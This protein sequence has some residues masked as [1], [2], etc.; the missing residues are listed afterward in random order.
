M[1]PV[2]VHVYTVYLKSHCK[3]FP[4]NAVMA[5]VI[6]SLPRM[7]GEANLAQA[8]TKVQLGCV[9]YS[10]D[11]AIGNELYIA[12]LTF[13]TKAEKGNTQVNNRGKVFL[14]S[15]PHQLCFLSLLL[16]M[17]LILFCFALSAPLSIPAISVSADLDQL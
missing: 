10:A 15:V 4:A 7:L 17:Y 14:F 11:L 5:H 13:L 12:L 3:T 6:H 8:Q 16:I 9:K 2:L 1:S